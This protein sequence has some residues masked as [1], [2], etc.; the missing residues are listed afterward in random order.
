MRDFTDED[1]KK[2]LVELLKATHAFCENH[3][4]TYF[5]DSGTLLGAIRHK[6]FIPWDDDI[7][8]CMPRPDYE[9]FIELVQKTPIAEHIY[10]Y[11]PEDGV[12]SFLKI[13]DARTKL[14]EHTDTLRVELGVYIDVF[15]KD[16]LPNNL[17]KAKG[18]CAK[19]EFYTLWYW[20]NKYSVKAWK[21][22][23]NIVKKLIAWVASLFIKDGL[24]PLRKVR[25]LAQKYS[26]YE[27]PYCATIVSGGMRNCVPT[28]LF[29]DKIMVPFEG[30]YYPAP[31]GYD[32]YLRKLFAHVNNGEYMTPPPEKDRIPHKHEIYWISS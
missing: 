1:L 25:K 28:E 14:I 20:F 21:K 13:C 6:G 22:T 31:I 19:A 9:R 4:I 7:D 26:F 30:E 12:N 2:V 23:K 32:Q 27:S 17:K 18:H 29:K 15:P 16:G 5:L 24:Y 11:H 3:N 8:I 10:L